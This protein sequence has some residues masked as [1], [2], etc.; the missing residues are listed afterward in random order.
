MTHDVLGRCGNWLLRRSM[1]PR[2][3]RLAKRWVEEGYCSISVADFKTF[4]RDECMYIAALAGYHD[5]GPDADMRERV[6]GFAGVSME[7]VEA[8]L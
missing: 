8:T 3:T 5:N 2:M 6:A 7:A 4:T 1:V